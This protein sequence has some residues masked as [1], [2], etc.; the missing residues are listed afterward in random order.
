MILSNRSC[1]K[2]IASCPQLTMFL[3]LQLKYGWLDGIT[4]YDAH[5]YRGRL[6]VTCWETILLSLQI[7][8][9]PI[10]PEVDYLPIQLHFFF[11]VLS[12]ERHNVRICTNIIFASLDNLSLFLLDE[13]SSTFIFVLFAHL[14]T[15]LFCRL[16]LLPNAVNLLTHEM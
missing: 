12:L 3:C 1:V 5:N 10:E 11:V 8:Y 13:C 14:S 7:C 15:A 9:C 4:I 6:I 16:L 2:E